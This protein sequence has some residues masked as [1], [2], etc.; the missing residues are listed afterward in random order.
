M[1]ANESV[2]LVSLNFRLGLFGFLATEELSR[3]QNGFSGNY[4]IS[5]II[6]G[7]DFK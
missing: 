1:V 2:V 6:T 5:D 3:E 4:A 7:I